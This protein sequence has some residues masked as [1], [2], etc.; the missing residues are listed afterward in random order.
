MNDEQK[1]LFD[2]NGYLVLQQVVPP[3]TVDASNRVLDRLETMDPDDFPEPLVLG[4]E[5]T[6]ENLYISNI[7]EADPVFRPLI[8]LPET[9]D[10]V[11]TVTGTRGCTCTALP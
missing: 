7:L 10:V 9:L 8:D 5:K 4:Q 3:E 2:L 6:P 11:E 1:Y